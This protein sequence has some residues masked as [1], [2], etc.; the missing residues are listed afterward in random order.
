MKITGQQS[1]GGEVKKKALI[2][3]RWDWSVP[4]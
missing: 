4:A 2:K 3:G 1:N